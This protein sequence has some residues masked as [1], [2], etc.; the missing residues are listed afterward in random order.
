MQLSFLEDSLNSFTSILKL[1]PSNT[2]YVVKECDKVELPV[3]VK[4]LPDP[5]FSARVT[6]SRAKRTEGSLP[7]KEGPLMK[8]I[9]VQKVK[10]NDDVQL[11]ATL[12]PNPVAEIPKTPGFLQKHRVEKNENVHHTPG[13]GQMLRVENTDNLGHTPVFGQGPRV[14]DSDELQ[15]PK[16]FPAEEQGD[17]PSLHLVQS[18]KELERLNSCLTSVND[19]P[20]GCG[21]EFQQFLSGPM[22]ETTPGLEPQKS[23]TNL[24]SPHVDNHSFT[25]RT[26]RGEAEEEDKENRNPNGFWNITAKKAL[27]SGKLLV[28]SACK[29]L[30]ESRR[31]NQ[32]AHPAQGNPAT[33]MFVSVGLEL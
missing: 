16:R 18:K 11:L 22:V 12:V 30:S 32:M 25:P 28:S 24:R 23:V 8:R 20:H 1:S 33:F 27:T 31:G 21:F 29:V 13:S 19:R 4:A 3:P 6:R 14:E 5:K 10:S 17:S 9:K 26:T 2:T 15:V 7:V